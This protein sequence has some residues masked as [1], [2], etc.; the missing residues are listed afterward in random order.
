MLSGLFALHYTTQGRECKWQMRHD[1]PGI[2]AA[3][4]KKRHST[5][6][7]YTLEVCARGMGAGHH[8]VCLSTDWEKWND[9]RVCQACSS[10]RSCCTRV[11]ES[12]KESGSEC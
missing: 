8:P 12:E 10:C 6:W 1:S 5:C 2:T 7:R 11:E 9:P 4:V 3:T